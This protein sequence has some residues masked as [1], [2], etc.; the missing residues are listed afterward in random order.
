MAF[1]RLAAFVLCVVSLLAAIA[2]GCNGNDSTPQ[3]A[4]LQLPDAGIP[5]FDGMVPDTARPG[6]NNPTYSVGGTVQ[7]LQG[8]GM[9]LQ[10]NN[11]ETVD[12]LS[13]G[14]FTFPSR[15]QVGQVFQVTVLRQ[16][17]SP[18]Q[19][20]SV[21]GGVGQIGNG[22]YTAITVNCTTNKFTLGGIV[23]GLQGQLVLSNN[24]TDTVTLTGN[25]SFSFPTL[26][27]DG[28]TWS[29]HVVTQPKVPSQSCAITAGQNGTIQSADSLAVRI[30]CTTNSFPV[31][32]VMNGLQSSVVL[33]NNGVPQ[34]AVTSNGTFFLNAAPSGSGYNISVYQQ[35]TSPA[36]VCSV[37]NAT[38]TVG[39][40]P[41]TTVRVD[42]ATQ[43]FT[44]GGTLTGLPQGQSVTLTDNGA[45]PLVVSANGGF[46]FAGTVPSGAPYKVRVSV[47]PDGTQCSVSNGTGFVQQSNVTSVLV[48]CVPL[49]A[50]AFTVGSQAFI[51][52]CSAP[53]GASLLGSDDGIY[54]GINLPFGIS[55]FG[56]SFATA[57]VASNGNLQFGASANGQFGG[58]GPL[59]IAGPAPAAMP[60]WQDLVQRCGVCWKTVGVAPNR[61]FVVEWQDARVFH[62]AVEEVACVNPPP[63]SDGGGVPS[64]GGVDILPQATNVSAAAHL[65][66]E[67][68]LNENNGTTT[69]DYVYQQMQ[70]GPAGAEPW[71][72]GAQNSGASL[73]VTYDYQ[74]DSNTSSSQNPRFTFPAAIQQ[75][76]FSLHFVP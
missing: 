64:D 28:A 67:V 44:V 14:G 43:A 48:N 56:E 75:P 37:S 60:M 39:D 49:P 58:Q 59:P 55:W 50:R 72:I 65:T 51:D 33:A 9:I 41:V 40:S 7:G 53:D 24:S 23:L 74:N 62:D 38:G 26:M 36:Q 27:D 21:N 17:Q 30:Q 34:P 31:G 47:Q 11:G 69:M 70:L 4:D 12:I 19:S 13:D 52:A 8:S 54:F 32:G 63:Q 22:N 2:V 61:Q 16:P 20:C 6:D 15:L 57:T 5:K 68:V 29:I 45:N 25:G 3:A 46:T 66:F 71:V 18:D 35:P 73:G 1:R 42:C 76:G 10:I